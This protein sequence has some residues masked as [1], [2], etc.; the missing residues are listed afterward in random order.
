VPIY[1]W[2]HLVSFK[3]VLFCTFNVLMTFGMLCVI[4]KLHFIPL[5]VHITLKLVSPAAD[6]QQ[7]VEVYGHSES[8][9]QKKVE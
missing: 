3:Q 2:Q 4:C 9:V 8:T 5:Y 7:T 1:Y 6:N